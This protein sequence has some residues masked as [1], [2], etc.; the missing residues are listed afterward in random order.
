MQARRKYLRTSYEENKEDLMRNE[1][2]SS[3]LNVQKQV[4][5]RLEF[6]EIDESIEQQ[7]E[8]TIENNDQLVVIDE[9]YNNR[10]GYT[11]FNNDNTFCSEPISLVIYEHR[12]D[13]GR[14][15]QEFNILKEIDLLEQH[16]TLNLA[17][18]DGDARIH[19]DL[20]TTKTQFAEGFDDYIA[21]SN[22]TK[23]DR[24]NLA[25]FLHNT[26][27][28]V[29]DLPF[30]AKRKADQL[31]DR[32]NHDDDEW[33]SVCSDE[34]SPATTRN[35]LKD[36][37]IDLSGRYINKQSRFFS[38]DQ[39]TDDCTVFLG[40]NKNLLHCPTCSYPRFRACSNRKC[41]NKGGNSCIHLLRDGL[42]LKQL[43]YRPLII[44]IQDLLAIPK[45]EYYLNYE[46][47]HNRRH[48]SHRLSDFMDGEIARGHLKEMK[49]Y[50]RD[51]IEDDPD[52][53]SD[54]IL[55]NLLLSE[56][57]D[58][59]QLFKSYV[60][61][62]WPLCIGILNMPPNLR[63]KVGLSYFL[64]ALYTGKHTEAERVLFNDLICEE[65]RCLYEG[66]EYE[67]NGRK[68]FIQ[69]RLVMHIL[70]TK[71]AEPV[72]GYQSNANSNFGCSNCG[73]VTGIHIGNKCVYLGH[74]NYLPQLNVLRF[75]GQTG[76]CCPAGFYDY[77][78]K[79]QWNVEEHFHHLDAGHYETFFAE[80][81]EIVS[82]VINQKEKATKGL[83]SFDEQR[84]IVNSIIS[85]PNIQSVLDSKFSA[86]DGND[87]T[88]STIVNY[89]FHEK[90]QYQWFHTG[91]FGFE[92]IFKPFG[93]FLYY[94]H[95]DYRTRKPFQ[96][97]PYDQY[98]IYAHEA[99]TL[100]SRSKSKTKKSVHG[101]QGLWYW[102]RLQYADLET[103]FTWPLIHAISGVVVK[104]LKLI[105]NDH[106]QKTKSSTT[107]FY[108]LKKLR[109]PKEKKRQRVRGI[110][111]VTSAKEDNENEDD[112]S[113]KEDDGNR[114][115]ESESEV[116]EDGFSMD[117]KKKF[118]PPYPKRKAPYQVFSKTNTD[119][120]QAWLECVLLPPG[121]SDDWNVSL[122]SP[123]S[124][125]ISQKL[126][127]LLCYWDFVMESLSIH[128]TYKTLFRMLANDM[129]RLLSYS[130]DKSDVENLLY[131]VIETIATWEGMMPTESNSFQSHELVDLPLSFKYYGPPVAVGELAG[132]RMMKKMKDW[133]LKTNLG[134]NTSFLKAVMRKQIYY[135]SWKMNSMYSRWPDKDDPNFSRRPSTTQ[136]I[137][138]EFP[139]VIR[140]AERHQQMVTLNEFEV[141]N[142]CNTLYSEVMRNFGGKHDECE[143]SAI[144]RIFNN[145]AIISLTWINK[146][147]YYGNEKH[148]SML[149][150][151]DIAV[152]RNLLNFQ[153]EFHRTA[154]V[155][156]TKFYSRG[157]E[158]RET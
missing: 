156:G 64:A 59:G 153:P 130:I 46:R 141:E 137:Y 116:E 103:Q 87:A 44:L 2:N 139:F 104:V 62:F 71:A 93:E 52:N 119:C 40:E 77:T 131:C 69:A 79:K 98:V 95:Q 80:R 74:R 15:F 72:M 96:R 129:T 134:G 73:G 127:M 26:L 92:E 136:L 55:I 1:L 86:C 83:T 53:R 115:E 140:F 12:N 38:F 63:G 146:L 105:I 112:D 144:Y 10:S 14:I 49:K 117:E 102:A 113:E 90:T 50:G 114:K 11:Q 47:R 9:R 88:K 138:N 8:T 122:T 145:K 3:V 41:K 18:V 27:E 84:T 65:L 31:D 157:S 97:V 56:F 58:S 125:K 108:K 60:F 100:N 121:L 36:S 94:R 32:T 4:E 29:I 82:T 91:E 37:A 126:K 106:Y 45:F 123:S 147:K 120:V 6:A 148:S 110:A 51:W 21:S 99:E 118:R 17:V 42:P 33:E 57:Y 34:S 54:S 101:I 158:C 151:V 128:K 85:K 66:I 81:W 28:G 5:N 30:T 70:D 154:L 150:A 76:Y 143:K 19:P 43:Y 23:K 152:A 155:Y 142:L 16:L 61:D 20:Q 39:C 107:V 149:K 13:N 48:N 135:E 132:E 22:T 68:Y 24:K 109:A 7:T 67:I 25:N 124:M 75:F 133:K 111:K 89:M 35:L 78:K